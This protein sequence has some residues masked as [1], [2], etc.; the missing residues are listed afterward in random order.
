ML[1]KT[2]GSVAETGKTLE[3][4]AVKA[5]KGR[6][7]REKAAR[8]RSVQADSLK[9]AAE[10]WYDPGAVAG[11]APRAPVVV[12]TWDLGKA[13]GFDCVTKPRESGKVP[14]EATPQR[15]LK[16]APGRKADVQGLKGASQY[17]GCEGIVIEGPNDKGRWEVQVDYQCETKTPGIQR[18]PTGQYKVPVRPFPL[19]SDNPG[20]LGLAPS[21]RS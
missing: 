16:L 7:S 18:Q 21:G 8:V 10:I 9:V 5:M 2:G 19:P 20:S 14:V 15:G 1:K 3:K 6:V 12:V 4:V 17:N 13:A 11:I